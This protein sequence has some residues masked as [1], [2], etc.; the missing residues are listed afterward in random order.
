M[1]KPYFLLLTI[2]FLSIAFSCYSQEQEENTKQK[3]NSSNEIEYIP[4]VIVPWEE[5]DVDEML[6]NLAL[7]SLDFDFES[8]IGG[9]ELIPASDIY[10][11]WNNFD[12]N[13]YNADPITD[14]VPISLIGFNFPLKKFYRVNSEF[15]QRRYRYHYG[16]D[17]K[18]ERGDTV[19]SSLGGMI[20]IAQS[21]NKKNGYG[22]Y[23]VVRHFNGLETVY[24]H[25]DK[26][27]V[28]PNQVVTSGEIIGLAG[29]TGRSTGPHLHYEVRY[30]GKPI[31]PR[32]VI[33]FDSTLMVKNE[34][35]ELTANHFVYPK[36]SSRV[37]SSTS[38]KNVAANTESGVW[39]V[40]NGDTLGRI[41]LKTGR[42]V[43]SLCSLNGITRTKILKIGQ[44]IK[45]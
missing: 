12:V 29:N 18:I 40:R 38:T 43:S 45:Y 6:N 36:K 17:L 4:I 27:L 5:E 22:Y 24:G 16:I 34:T 28:E 15:G 11:I 35:I 25:L 2:F 1:N 10:P 42:S 21:K 3:S 41:A 9:D 20:R 8:G 33:D 26:V 23:V 39:V 30:Q 44:K 7:D 13:P 19:V 37:N 32:D 14:T 31:N